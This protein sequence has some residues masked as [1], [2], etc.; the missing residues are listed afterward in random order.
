M[1]KIGL[2]SPIYVTNYQQ[3]KNN[4]T[5]TTS[6]KTTLKYHYDVKHCTN[7]IS[8]KSNNIENIKRPPFRDSS[9][10]LFNEVY[11]DYKTS[12]METSVEDIEHIIENIE[13]KTNQPREKILET[14][15]KATQ[16]GNMRSLN[17]IADKLNDNNCYISQTLTKDI[18]L[19]STLNYYFNQKELNNVNGEYKAVFLDKNTLETFE[20]LKET[21]PDKFDNEIINNKDTKYFILSG[22]N[23][24]INFLNRTDNLEK[25]TIDLLDKTNIDIETISRAHNL[26]ITPIIIKND[27]NPSIEN[28]YNQLKPEQ[29]TAKEL[30]TLIDATS[31]TLLSNKEHQINAKS[32]LVEYLDK[33]LDVYSPEKLAQMSK[34]IHD[35]IN[36]IISSEGKSMNDVYYYIHDIQKS[37]A[38]INYQYQLVNN[39]AKNKFF[40]N[41]LDTKSPT[42]LN[43]KTIVILDDCSISGDSLK[44]I[45][46]KAYIYSKK[47]QENFNIIFAPYILTEKAKN[48]LTYH[49][50]T[51]GRD[52]KDKII[53]LKKENK[54]NIFN[55]VNCTEYILGTVLG[56]SGY[57]NDY[58]C[59]ILPYMAPDNN[60]EFAANIALLHSIFYA[61]RQLKNY[62]ICN[63]LKSIKMYFGDAERVTNSFENLLKAG[64]HDNK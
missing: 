24:G 64:E 55:N 7:T 42:N 18:G 8:F 57:D 45:E 31:I 41:L 58:S 63:I 49:I 38:P 26:G 60:S 39:I 44:K 23:N 15:Q 54:N 10:K 43:G 52:K 37:Y 53:E 25:T 32:G 3:K 34:K 33:K 36:Q 59:T 11:Q 40:N 48:E 47:R 6:Q 28:I 5:I 30:E 14:M 9:F 21:N 27:N 17:V 1:S 35:N 29:M 4:N 22:F 2:Y 12:L 62:K 56:E 61:N 19:N 51:H 46:E 50:E 20:E 13:K 16:F